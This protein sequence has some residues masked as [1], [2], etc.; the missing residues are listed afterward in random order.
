I[1]WRKGR[2]ASL[3]SPKLVVTGVLRGFDA[4]TNMVLDQATER[5]DKG[6]L[7]ER[8]LGFVVVKGSQVAMVAPAT[9]IEEVSNPFFTNE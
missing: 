6:G 5:I 2:W 4:L 1:I 8:T 7:T 9:G 3:S